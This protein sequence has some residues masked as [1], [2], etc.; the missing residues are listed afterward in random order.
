[1]QGAS[2]TSG[3]SG[4]GGLYISGTCSSIVT[5]GG[6]A[7]GAVGNALYVSQDGKVWTLAYQF[8]DADKN[9]I[10]ITTM[11]VF[12]NQLYVGTLEG[13]YC[14]GGTAMTLA[15]S[16]VGVTV[17][18]NLVTVNPSILPNANFR[19]VQCRF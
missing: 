2:A 13:L 5:S 1:M 11:A 6:V 16:S 14:D 7:F 12:S 15:G 9:P 18:M 3:F 8:L 10:P 4:S 19:Q 17:N